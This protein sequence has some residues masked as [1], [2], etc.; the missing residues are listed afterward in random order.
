MLLDL[1]R[2]DPWVCQGEDLWK[3]MIEHEVEH[4]GKKN[5]IHLPRTKQESHLNPPNCFYSSW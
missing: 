1:G 5:E 2:L 3:L 4:G